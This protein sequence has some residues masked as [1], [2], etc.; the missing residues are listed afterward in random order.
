MYSTTI[1]H[2]SSPVRDYIPITMSIEFV[3]QACSNS[4]EY[5]YSL[6][7]T[8][9]GYIALV[10][11]D[12][13][14]LRLLTEGFGRDKSRL[15]QIVAEQYPSARYSENLLV[16]LQQ[17]LVDYIDGSFDFGV[18]WC[19]SFDCKIDLSWA[20]EF[21]VKVLRSCCEIE[22]GATISYGQ[23]ALRCGRVGAGRAVGG[24]MARNRIPLIIPCHRVISSDG[25]L[26]GYSGGGQEVKQRLLEHEQTCF[27]RYN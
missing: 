11:R 12:E 5:Q 21:S 6:S 1:F 18:S 2:Q 13:V 23:L 22:P 9:W 19:D 26:G 14:L 25:K 7:R 27:R 24:A 4:D 17:S 10:C 8:K 16:G 3:S 15:M 20:G